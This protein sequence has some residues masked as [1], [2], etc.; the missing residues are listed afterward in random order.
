MKLTIAPILAKANI[1]KP[2]VL[3]TDASQ[4]HVAAMLMQYDDNSLPQVVAYFSKK[5]RPA[6]RRYS[7]TDREALAI[8]LVC[9]KFNSYLWGT[10]FAIRTDHQPVVSVFKHRTKSPRMNRWILEMKDYQYQIEYKQG[11]KNVVADHLSRPVRIIQNNEERW[12]GKSKEELTEM[13]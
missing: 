11:K 1:H 2:F 8:V 12:L 5:L 6:E 7:A 13:L 9:R 10:R 4:H 3:E